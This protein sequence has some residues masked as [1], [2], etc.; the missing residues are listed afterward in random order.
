MQEEWNDEELVEKIFVDNPPYNIEELTKE[1]ILSD[2]VIDYLVSIKNPVDRIRQFEKVRDKAKELKVASSFKT[3]YK[4]KD[5]AIGIKNLEEKSSM[6]ITFPDMNNITYNTTRYEIDESGAI[7]ENVYKV[8][9]ILVC[10]H[11]ILPIEKYKNLE[12]GTEKIKLAFYKENKWNYRTVNKSMIASTYNIVKLSNFGVAVNSENAKLLIRYLSE[13]ENLNRDKIKTNVSVSRLGWVDNEFIPYTEKYTCDVENSFEHIYDAINQNGDYHKWKE[14]MRELR[15]KSK[16]LRFMM[17]ASFAS[18]LVEKIQVNSFI[19]HLWG[20]SSTGKTVALKICASIWGN[21]KLGKL[22]SSLS[23]TE[24]AMEL[25][26]NFLYNIPCIYD[27]YQMAKDKYSSYDTLIYMLTEGKGKDRGTQDCGLRATT[28]WNNISILS[29]EEPITSQTSK[30]GVK[31]RVI[32][33]E[34]NNK[35][36]ENGIETVKFIDNNY[37]FAGKE[38]IEII[39]S[40]KDLYEEF[41]RIVSSLKEHLNYSKQINAIATILVAD[42]IVSELIFKDNPITL[43]E[44]KGYFSKEIDEADRYINLIIDI[45]NSHM[46]NFCIDN[47]KKESSEQPKGEIWGKIEKDGNNDE[48]IYY[49]FIPSKLYDILKLHGI[50][51]HG[52]KAKMADKGYVVKRKNEYTI[53]TKINGNPQRIIRIKNI[54]YHQ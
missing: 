49:E 28:T 5:D 27:E 25:Q 8:G 33:L 17:A 53:N 47:E 48:I 29:G 18:P 52:I 2:M 36:I 31:N 54:Y 40:K 1:E 16:T 41:N 37:G 14:K 46:N 43:E 3:I 4:Q 30:E 45:A 51:W 11:P 22:V 19:V 6:G 12:D 7:Y 21:P 13:I 39:Q 9:K 23:N 24:T 50:D 44:A 26:S 15:K 32:E 10:Y 20:K 42:K 38:F 34:E 35:I